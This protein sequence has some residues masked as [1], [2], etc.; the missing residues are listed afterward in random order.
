[1]LKTATRNMI[2]DREIRK[3]CQLGIPVIRMPG[4]ASNRK[5]SR[6]YKT[7]IPIPDRYSP[8]KILQRLQYGMCANDP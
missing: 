4:S 5:Q 1:M 2:G 3:I 7:N 8:Q 6:T